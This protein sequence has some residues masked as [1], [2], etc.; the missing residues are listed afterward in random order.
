M[1]MAIPPMREPVDERN[2]GR[3]REQDGHRKSRL[4]MLYLLATGQARDRQEVAALLGVHRNTIGRWLARYAA[5]GL[6]ALLATYIPRRQ[7]GLPRAGGARQ[8][9]ADPPP[10]RRLRLVCSPAQVGGTHPWRTDQLQDAL[11]HRA[12]ALPEQAQSATPQSHQEPLRPFRRS[13]PPVRPNSS[14]SSQRPILAPSGSS[15]RTKAASA[16]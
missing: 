12:H 11:H 13:R 4:Q 15:V 9:G 3:Q 5:G 6:E 2:D 8:P 14:R 1:R 10:S 16:S 7:T